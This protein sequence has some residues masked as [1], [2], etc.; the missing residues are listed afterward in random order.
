MMRYTTVPTLTV[1]ENTLTGILLAAIVTVVGAA[2]YTGA[3]G[4]W[5]PLMATAVA[6]SLLVL[7]VESE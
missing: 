7:F 3:T 2:Y 1:E 5:V 4:N 6:V